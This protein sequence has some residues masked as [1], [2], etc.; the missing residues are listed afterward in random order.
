[1]ADPGGPPAPPL[2]PVLQ[3]VA[4][5]VSF[6][7]AIKLAS[8]FGGTRVYIPMTVNPDSPLALCLGLEVAQ[9]LADA[10]GHGELAVPLGPRRHGA[11]LSQAIAK[12]V[13][14]G[15]SP[16]TIARR[17][18]CTERTIKRHLA[19]MKDTGEPPKKLA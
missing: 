8:D 4:D 7:A 3:Q 9:R 14:E 11:R 17:L 6:E 5:A 18:G 19:Q 15:L 12:L 13:A 2:P 10:I 1:M 16:N